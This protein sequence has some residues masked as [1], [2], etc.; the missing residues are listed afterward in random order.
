[1]F[2]FVFEFVCIVDYVDGFSY[3]EPFLHPW[4]EA[5]LIMMD[6]ICWKN[7]FKRNSCSTAG[8]IAS[9]CNH[10]GNQSGGSS[11]NWTE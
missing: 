1:V 11:E 4:D 9:L 3:I 7:I 8:G 6:D 2:F 5:F 10:S